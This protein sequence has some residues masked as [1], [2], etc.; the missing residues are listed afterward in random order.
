MKI[1]M[2]GDSTMKYNNIYTAMTFDDQPVE[3]RKPINLPERLYLNVDNKSSIDISKKL[4]LLHYKV[5]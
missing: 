1:F 4:L 2:M 5:R 3:V